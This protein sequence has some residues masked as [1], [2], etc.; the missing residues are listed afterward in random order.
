MT[1]PNMGTVPNVIHDLIII[2]EKMVESKIR[3]IHNLRKQLSTQ[4]LQ[5]KQQ[6]AQILEL[7]DRIQFIEETEGVNAADVINLDLD[8]SEFSTSPISRDPHHE[9]VPQE[10]IF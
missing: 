8:E 6:V 2:L 5:C 1:R 7:S 9:F 3:E 10:Q 4:Q